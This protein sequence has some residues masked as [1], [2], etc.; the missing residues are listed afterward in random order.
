MKIFVL[1]P[2]FLSASFCKHPHI[3]PS[4]SKVQ[5]CSQMPKGKV[6]TGVKGGQGS[7]GNIAMA[8]KEGGVNHVKAEKATESI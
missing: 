5:T 2:L 8:S 1:L 4:V 6:K 3:S 7:S